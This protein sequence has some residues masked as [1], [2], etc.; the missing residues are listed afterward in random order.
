MTEAASFNLGQP[1][2]SPILKIEDEDNKET[3]TEAVAMN[4]KSKKLTTAADAATVREDVLIPLRNWIK[5]DAADQSRQKNENKK[6]CKESM[7][8]KATVAYGIVELLVRCPNNNVALDDDANIRID[9]FA[10]CVCK[11]TADDRSSSSPSWDDIKGV[12]MLSSGLSLSIE[13]PSYLSC[14]FEEGGEKDDQMGRY[15]EVELDAAKSLVAIT[16]DCGDSA[17]VKKHS[18]HV[19]V[20]IILY[21]LFTHEAFPDDNHHRGGTEPTRKRAKILPLKRKT[22]GSDLFNIPAIERMQKL[23]VPAPVCRMM[24]NLLESAL[25]GDG[26]AHKAWGKWVKIYTCC[27]STQIVSCLTM[28][29]MRQITCNSSTGKKGYM[30]EI[31]R[32]LSSLMLSVE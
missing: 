15:L 20:A 5:G 29:S 14:L 3:V 4:E 27:C 1:S 19:L 11:K 30:G 28:S 23:G 16:T 25:G 21:E 17:Q 24:Q 32:R 13:E 7:I 31:K 12:S 22:F 6:R 26:Y 9:N 8:R 2:F 10:V 18:C